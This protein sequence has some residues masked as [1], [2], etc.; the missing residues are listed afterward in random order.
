[1]EMVCNRQNT[2][3]RAFITELIASIVLAVLGARLLW[4][5]LRKH[6]VG[7]AGPLVAGKT[8]GKGPVESRELES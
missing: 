7:K 3:Y 5:T 1:M 2:V 8:V 4:L 6:G